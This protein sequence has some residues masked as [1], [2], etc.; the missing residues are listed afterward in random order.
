MPQPSLWQHWQDFFQ[1]ANNFFQ[2]QN[3][4]NFKTNFFLKHMPA[5]ISCDFY[6]LSL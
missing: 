1:N 4:G 6:G 3:S 2:I 5:N